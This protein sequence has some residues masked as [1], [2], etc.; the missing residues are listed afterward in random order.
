MQDGIDGIVEQVAVMADHDHGARIARQVILEPE[1]AFEIEIVGRLVEQQEIGLREQNRRERDAHAPA[2]GEF[3]AGPLLRGLREAKAG[4]DRGR[5]R[6]R[7]IGVDIHEP[8][9]DLGDAMRIVLG[10][11][12]RQKMRALGI[13]L[14]HDFDQRLGT[15]RCFLRQAPEGVARGP[16]DLAGLGVEVAG[17]DVEQGGLA[18]AVAA[19]Q[20]DARAVRDLHGGM[21]DQ[22]SARDA[23]GKVFDAQH[24]DAVLIRPC[25][26]R[27]SRISR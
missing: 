7:R 27:Q 9:L 18:G 6:G 25:A 11:R 24:G 2:A 22:E 23:D 4:Q 17:D 5:A 13:G 26:M 12:L 21:I 10:F 19:D 8:R 16:R 1:R 15:G 20:A 14:E 3:R